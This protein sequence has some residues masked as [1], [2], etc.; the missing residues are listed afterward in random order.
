MKKN[1]CDNDEE[2][3]TTLSL[4]KNCIVHQQEIFHDESSES[5]VPVFYKCFKANDDGFGQK[6]VHWSDT[7]Q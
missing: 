7:C 3:T 2:A 1:P 5:A 4:E 6:A